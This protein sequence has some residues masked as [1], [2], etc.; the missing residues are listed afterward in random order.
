MEQS[1]SRE[2]N[3]SSANQES[4]NN[5]WNLNVL[6]RIHNSPQPVLIQSQINV[7]HAS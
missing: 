1:P 7:V 6:Q 2:T 3:R 4:P 5:L